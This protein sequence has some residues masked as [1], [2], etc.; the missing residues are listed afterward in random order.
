M[1]RA[2]LRHNRDYLAL[3][4][5]QGLWFEPGTDH[6]YS[7]GGYVLLGEVIAKAS[8]MDYY[9]YL[10]ERVF[11]PAGMTRTSAPLEGDGT[12]GL[13]RGYTREGA[14]A[15]GERDNAAGRPARGSAAGGSYS[16]VDDFL[17]LDRALARGALCSREWSSWVCEGPRRAGGLPAFGFGGGAPGISTEWMHEGDTVLILF[18]NRDPEVTR[19]VL[20]PVRAIVLRMNGSARRTRG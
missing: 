7:N 3:I 17:A 1:D 16:S 5:D 9:D 14:P 15:G 11:R 12:P 2:T 10:E 4:R 20:R 13:A 19:E 8:G 6:R 18:T